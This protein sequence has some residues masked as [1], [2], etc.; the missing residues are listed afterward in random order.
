MSQINKQAIASAFGRAASCYERFDQF[1]RRCGLQLLTLTGQR[2][3]PRVLD[4]GCG[5][6]RFSQHWQRQGSEVT[7]L[8]LSASMLVIA[9]QR[10]VAQHF[11]QADIEHLP[12]SDGQFDLCWSNLAVQWCSNLAQA[13]NELYRITNPGGWLIFSTLAQGTLAELHHAWRGV[14]Y[15]LHANVYPDL[16]TLSASSPLPVCWQQY[17]ITEYYPDVLSALRSI[18]GVGAT[19][20]QHGRHNTVLT[21]RQLQQLAHS[22]PRLRGQIPLT[23]Q[24]VSGVIQ[25]D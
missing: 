11:I 3:F 24:L 19:H 2:R 14:D 10:K 5:T 4:A 23:Y 8:D 15:H 6:G 25:H 16:A 17:A 1:Q 18:K 7:A 21:R 9:R 12:L 20:L 13:L 22:W